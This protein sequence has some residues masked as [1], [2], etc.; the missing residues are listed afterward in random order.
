MAKAIVALVVLLGIG[1]LIRQSVTTSV[2]AS[3]VSAAGS[4]SI[5]PPLG[6]LDPVRQGDPLPDG[7]RQLLPRDAIE[8]IYAPGFVAAA[9]S[10]W[11]DQELVVGVEIEGESK[12]YPIE[13]LNR[14]EI[15]NDELG[16]IPI[17][18]SW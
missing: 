7:F 5:E 16:G 9:E 13:F 6:V 8:P 18:V 2:D 10:E 4:V 17:L 1:L 11:R 15:V 12:A 14:R 3:A